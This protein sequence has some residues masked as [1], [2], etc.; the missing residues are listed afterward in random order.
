MTAGRTHRLELIPLGYNGWRLCNHR[1]GYDE[2]L[3]VAYIERLNS[4]IFAAVWVCDAQG[5][6]EFVSLDEILRAAEHHL[7]PYVSTDS[8]PVPIPHRAP[9]SFR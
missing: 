2:E 4:G 7:A 3:V 1:P 5:V 8:K 9:L 6:E